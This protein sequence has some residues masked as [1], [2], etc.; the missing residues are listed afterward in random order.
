LQDW[1]YE[2]QFEPVVRFLKGYRDASR[3]T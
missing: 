2:A 3:Q 1:N